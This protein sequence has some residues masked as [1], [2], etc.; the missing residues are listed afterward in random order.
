MSAGPICFHATSVEWNGQGSSTSRFCQTHQCARD[1]T[2]PSM[3]RRLGASR[4]GLGDAID[5]VR[6]ELWD[7]RA[8]D[9][10]KTQGDFNRGGSQIAR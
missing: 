2:E 3:S 4:F 6:R 10:E 7:S 9:S 1:R 5:V 8:A